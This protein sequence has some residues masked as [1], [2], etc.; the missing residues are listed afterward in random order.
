MEQNEHTHFYLL[1]F[2]ALLGI[3]STALA[4]MIA[5]DQTQGFGQLEQVV[6]GDPEQNAPQ[7]N[8]SQRTAVLVLLGKRG[9]GLWPPFQPGL[10]FLTV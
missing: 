10:R 8:K 3:V 1:L 4:V 9:W 6:L 2:P 5:R 7:G